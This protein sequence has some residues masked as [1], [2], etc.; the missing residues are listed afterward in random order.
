MRSLRSRSSEERGSPRQDKPVP[1]VEFRNSTGSIES[2]RVPASRCCISLAKALYRP[3]PRLLQWPRMRPTKQQREQRERAEKERRFLDRVEQARV[4]AWDRI[5]P[6]PSP[7]LQPPAR[8]Q[9]NRAA[10]AEGSP[11]TGEPSSPIPSTPNTTDNV[12][13]QAIPDS[14]FNLSR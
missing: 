9:S 3:R 7:Q 8:Q 2:P 11:Q 12:N 6:Y 10:Q 1:D 13:C 14:P 4:L 5:H